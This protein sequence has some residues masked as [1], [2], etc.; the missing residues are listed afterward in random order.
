MNTLELKF[1]GK[2][3]RTHTRTDDTYTHL[4]AGGSLEYFC[5]FGSFFTHPL[6]KKLFNHYSIRFRFPC[7][8]FDFDYDSEML[9]LPR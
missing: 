6:V 3:K 8:D 7:V 9:G 5:F 2:R 1:W 4:Y